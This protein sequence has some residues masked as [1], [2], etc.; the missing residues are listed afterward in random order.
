LTKKYFLKFKDLSEEREDWESVAI[1]YLNIGYS[2]ELQKKYSK[3]FESYQKVLDLKGSFSANTILAL[4]YVN[5]ASVSNELNKPKEALKYCESSL[6]I[7]EKYGFHQYRLSA[8]TEKVEAYL[9]LER[10]EEAIT[11]AKKT[12]SEAEVYG[13][14][15]VMPNLQKILSEGYQGIGN[16]KEAFLWQQKH[17]LLQDSIYE[18]KRDQEVAE[19]EISHQ[20][21]AKEAENIQLKNEKMYQAE[22]LRNK[23]KEF[24]VSVAALLLFILLTGLLFRIKNKLK[25]T[26]ADLEKIVNERTKALL[27]SNVQLQQS[28]EELKRFAFIASHDLKE[29]LKGTGS[30]ISLMK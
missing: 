12:I 6:S 25:S 7:S 2:Y 22:A 19:L 9:K 20:T 16:Y 17:G 27:E 1:A 15:D 14:Y 5:I 3:A 24:M 26:N 4:T 29:P 13:V 23:N 11:G 18:A 8:E 28:N 30:F 21:K 10:F